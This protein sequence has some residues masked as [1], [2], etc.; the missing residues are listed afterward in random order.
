MEI[1][2]LASMTMSLNKAEVGQSILSKSL[3]KTAEVEQQ[4]QQQKNRQM[5]LQAPKPSTAEAAMTG[6]G[7]RVNAYA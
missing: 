2:G 4:Q 6:K 3:Q 5:K 7:T 1:T